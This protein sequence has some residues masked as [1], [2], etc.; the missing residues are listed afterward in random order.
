MSDNKVLPI[1]APDW[2][3]L[4]LLSQHHPKDARDQA[5]F[6]LPGDVVCVGDVFSAGIIPA[7]RLVVPGP[8]GGE[9]LAAVLGFAEY[10]TDLTE[11]IL[12]PWEK[13]VDGRKPPSQFNLLIDAGDVTFSELVT[14]CHKG[15]ISRDTPGWAAMQFAFYYEDEGPPVTSKPVKALWAPLSVDIVSSPPD[16]GHPWP[17]FEC[18]SHWFRE[19]PKKKR[20][21]WF[22]KCFGTCPNTQC[23][24][25]TPPARRCWGLKFC[26]C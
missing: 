3:D 10:G 16:P 13:E 8:C 11:D 24:C 25:G 18:H 14:S 4:H 1:G 21:R 12:E 9:W 23:T 20:R 22:T 19:P 15:E 2:S 26:W 6:S 17:Y 5:E 7:I